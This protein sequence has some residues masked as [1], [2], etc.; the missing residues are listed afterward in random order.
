VIKLILRYLIAVIMI[1]IGVALGVL[2]TIS[3]QLRRK[4]YLEKQEK[5]NRELAAENQAETKQ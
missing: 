3:N 5:M 2:G 1:P 4:Q